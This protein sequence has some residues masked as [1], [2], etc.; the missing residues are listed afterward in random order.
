MLALSREGELQCS[1]LEEKMDKERRQSWAAEGQ[2][3]DPLEG[4]RRFYV[5]AFPRLDFGIIWLW[6]RISCMRQLHHLATLVCVTS[7]RW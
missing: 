4:D 6:F 5:S 7:R 1:E 2:S 3:R